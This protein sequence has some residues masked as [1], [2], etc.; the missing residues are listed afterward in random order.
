LKEPKN[1]VNSEKL[2]E[3]ME[4]ASKKAQQKKS[5]SYTSSQK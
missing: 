4:Q 1:K 5:N 3:V 2:Q